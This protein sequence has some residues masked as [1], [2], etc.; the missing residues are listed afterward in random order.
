MTYAEQLA[1]DVTNY[2]E[3]N[4]RLAD[5]SSREDLIEKLE[6]E[7]WTADS[8]TGNGSGSYTFSRNMAMQNVLE[9]M[10]EVVDALW[11]FDTETETIGRKFLEQDW[12]WF[13]VVVR[14]ALLSGAIYQVAQGLECKEWEE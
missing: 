14:C 5:Y 1:V 2:I 9:N 10:E 6:E 12:E 8:V 11:E 7:L 4:V 3:E 13:D